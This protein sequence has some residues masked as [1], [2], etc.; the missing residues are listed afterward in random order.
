MGNKKR[1]IKGKDGKLQGSLPGT[2][3]LPASNNSVE[4]PQKPFEEVSASIEDVY[5]KEAEINKTLSEGLTEIS[6]AF[7]NIEAIY[8]ERAARREEEAGKAKARLTE[9][10]AQAKAARENYERIV[11]EQEAKKLTNRIKNIF[12]KKS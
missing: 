3:N 12:R 5:N 8:K 2:P 6:Q 1:Y 7:E 9:L 11:A 4:L 10:E